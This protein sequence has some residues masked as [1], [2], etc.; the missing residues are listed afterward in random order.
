M[1]L[2]FFLAYFSVVL[3]ATITPGPNM[4]LAI[5]HG[6]V[7]GIS[8]TL[9]SAYGNLL[10]NLLLAIVS[11]AGIGVLL[12]ASATLYTA[13]KWLGAAYLIYLGFAVIFT[14]VPASTAVKKLQI[15][16]VKSPWGLFA[17]GLVIAIAN[18]KGVL[19]FSAIFTQIVGSESIS[20]FSIGIIFAT[21]TIIAFGCYMLYASAGCRLFELLRIKVFRNTYN[22][23]T[24][25]I[26]IIT[27]LLVGLKD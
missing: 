16:K 22:A 11:L 19:F 6:A 15:G 18:P 21:L 14:R 27:G 24:G 8:R 4:L 3:V 10:G 5:N 20:V 12:M 25:T 13:I 7:Y 2:Q 9:Y 17:D 1:T 23:I 26:F